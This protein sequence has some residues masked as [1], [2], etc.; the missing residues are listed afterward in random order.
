MR[1]LPDSL[2]GCAAVALAVVI[3]SPLRALDPVEWKFRQPVKV[4]APGIVAI[5]LPPATLDAARADWGDLR[6]VDAQGQE[7][8]FVV[9]R[10]ARSIV[11]SVAVDSFRSR[12]TDTATELLIACGEARIEELSLATPAPEFVK[13]ARVE[14]SADGEKW[15]VVDEGVPLFRQRGA[16]QL[17]VRVPGPHVRITIDDT[18]SRPV[19][20]T[21]ARFTTGRDISTER[22]ALEARIARRE[23]FAGETVLTLELAAAHVPLD[24]LTVTTPERLFTRRVTVGVRELRDEAAVERTMSGGTIYNVALEGD[25]RSDH[26]SVPLG[27]DAPSR[28][29]LVHIANDDSPPLAVSAI[30]ISRFEARLYFDAASAGEYALLVGHPHVAAPRYDVTRLP[31]TKTAQATLLTPGALGPTPG[32]RSPEALAGVALR[33]APLDPAAW[34]YRKKVQVAAK[35]VQ[36]LELDLD[37]LAHAQANFGDVRLLAGGTQVPYLLERPAVSRSLQ[38]EVTPANDPRRP[39]YSRWALRFPRAGLRVAQLSAASSTPLFQRSLRVFEK[40]T[41]DRG[42]TFERTLGSAEWK[43]TPGEQRPLLIPLPVPPAQDTVL[44]ETDNGDNPPIVLDAASATVPVARLLFKTE[45]P[46]PADP[47]LLYYGNREAAAPRY[48]LALVARPILAA[49]K[50]IATLAPEE[51]IRAEGWTK[52]IVARGRG[53]VIFWSV[54]VLV[55]IG[56]LA[57]VAKL[58]P[59]PPAT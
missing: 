16:Q 34:L 37:V 35:G 36:Q 59:K 14:T 49:E 57:V 7:I 3:T 40:I 43:R 1:L 29:L 45:A 52:L 58:L 17:S 19:P 48:D 26:R 32:Y 56:L 54:L 10:G 28:E 24:T 8:A 42:N 30:Q 51:A 23:E 12:L 11:R 55:V 31:L 47:L 38:L 15:Q 21:G 44:V 25:L 13:R 27:F 18:R 22:P 20:F 4:D 53:A 6:V 41:D 39:R 5:A 50:Q 46:G 33:G 2:A 9:Q